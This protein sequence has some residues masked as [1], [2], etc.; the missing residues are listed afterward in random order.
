MSKM[1]TNSET[2]KAWFDRPGENNNTRLEE[3]ISQL[4][5]AIVDNT[6]LQMSI[7]DGDVID[8][9]QSVNMSVVWV[10]RDL[11]K[12]NNEFQDMEN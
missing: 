10:L 6:E 2:L 11:Q 7:M 12:I 4:K 1:L 8:K 9:L 3:M 5:Q